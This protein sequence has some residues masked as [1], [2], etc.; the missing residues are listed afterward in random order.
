MVITIQ[1]GDLDVEVVRKDIK[2]MHLSVLPPEGRVRVAAPERTSLDAI[3]AFAVLRLPWIRR[4]QRKMVMQD[5]EPLRE[6]LDR[7]S[8]FVWGERVML[9][10]V[11]HG[12][13]PDVLRRPGKL[14]LKVRPDAPAEDRR[15][16][17]ESWYRAE[18]RRA[19]APSLQRWQSHLG[20]EMNRLFVQRMKTKWGSC[21]AA[22]RNV[23][24]NTDLAK[25][26]PECLDYVVLHELAHLRVR[27]HSPAFYDL[28]DQ[29]MPH[30]RA[31]RTLLNVL[32]LFQPTKPW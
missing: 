11:E 3:R 20:V 6:F 32:P 4:H 17:V 16:L 18:I 28:L 19:A 5:R 15:D 10:V 1:L 30:W 2:N 23:R 8:H 26:P 7:E 14:T 22:S 24:L 12:A 13:P 29:A 9:E 21:N 25:K 31:V 27:T